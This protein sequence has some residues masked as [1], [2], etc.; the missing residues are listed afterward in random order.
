MISFNDWIEQLDEMRR[1]EFLQ[2]AAATAVAAGMG[3]M[4]QSA[5]ADNKFDT[6]LG[7]TMARMQLIKGEG[8]SE[9]QFEYRRIQRRLEEVRRSGDMKDLQRVRQEAVRLYNLILLRKSDRLPQMFT[10]FYLPKYYAM[11][12]DLNNK[13]LAREALAEYKLMQVPSY[14]RQV[15]DRF[16]FEIKKYNKNIELTYEEADAVAKEALNDQKYKLLMKAV[17]AGVDAGR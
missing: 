5:Q 3:A 9:A 16:I 1:R 6:L 8:T 7:D 17:Q 14:R 12:D 4:P 13:E 2:G 15:I 11:V 10:K